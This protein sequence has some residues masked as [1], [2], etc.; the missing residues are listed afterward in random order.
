MDQ[1][2]T[3]EV[4]GI[5]CECCCHKPI[6]SC[7]PFSWDCIHCNEQRTEPKEEWEKA[8][9]SRFQRL[10]G[11]LFIRNITID[12]IKKFIKLHQLDMVKKFIDFVEDY[13]RRNDGMGTIDEAL[14][15]FMLREGYKKK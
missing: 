15:E 5:K 3:Q 2:T 13:T 9:D 4:D 8:F 7:D 14:E 1:N 6:H 11:D 10:R 12:D